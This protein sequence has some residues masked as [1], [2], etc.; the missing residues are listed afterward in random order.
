MWHPRPF[1]AAILGGMLVGLAT[2]STTAPMTALGRTG[3]ITLQ[4]TV[5][6]RM[7]HRAAVVWPPLRF[8]QFGVA[9]HAGRPLVV[10]VL[11]SLAL[12]PL[13][14]EQHRLFLVPGRGV[15]CRAIVAAH[16][17]LHGRP[18]YLSVTV[19]LIGSGVRP[20]A[21]A[22][23]LL[24]GRAVRTGYASL[25]VCLSGPTMDGRGNC[26][27]VVNGCPLNSAAN[28]PACYPAWDA[29]VA[30]EYQYDQ[31]RAL[32]I[33]L[34]PSIMTGYG[35]AIRAFHAFSLPRSRP[36]GELLPIG[37]DVAVMSA[38]PQARSARVVHVLRMEVTPTGAV[39]YSVR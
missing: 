11:S 38:I 25:T 15:D 26:D 12:R 6:V 20:I 1:Q 16:P 35:F 19:D 9:T 23:R 32:R 34:D 5:L 36:A 13:R 37:E 3:G 31:H 10:P 8:S 14:T 27:R 22:N 2:L 17:V 33:W 39:R 29:K 21:P 24:H 28:S 4:R 7:P 18:C 30:T